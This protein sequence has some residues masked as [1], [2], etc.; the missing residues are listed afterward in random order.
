MAR[1]KP[2]RIGDPKRGDVAETAGAPETGG[3]QGASPAVLW[4]STNP[5][6]ESCV[7]RS[8]HRAGLGM[9]A[10]YFE[11]RD[12]ATLENAFEDIK[13]G[14]A[15]ALVTC[16]DSLTLA[17]R[18]A[19]PTCAAA[20]NTDLGPLGSTR[21][22]GRSCPSAR[23][24][25]SGGARPTT[26]KD[27]EGD[28]ARE[29]ADRAGHAIRPHPQSSDG[30]ESWID[31]PCPSASRIHR[32]Q[33]PG[34]RW[35]AILAA[36]ER[37]LISFAHQR[38]GKAPAILGEETTGN[39]YGHLVTS[40]RI[41][42]AG[43]ISAA[44]PSRSCRDITRR[45]RWAEAVMDRCSQGNSEKASGTSTRGGGSSTGTLALPPRCQFWF[46]SGEYYYLSD[47]DSDRHARIIERAVNP[48]AIARVRTRRWRSKGDEG[49]CLLEKP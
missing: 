43:R 45:C 34:W 10:S 37:H 48:A 12:A 5:G 36:R 31:F 25:P 29:P 47:S 2:Y 4:N 23:L 16:W 9:Q 15:D 33:R 26:S 6:N 8:A 41:G 30:E 14:K 49:S 20:P 42:D 35:R 3:H 11:V 7:K 17:M 24:P 40:R 46:K 44:P 1:R 28:E 18:D 21:R 38:G 19:S 22:P 27:P 13:R 32:W 39:K